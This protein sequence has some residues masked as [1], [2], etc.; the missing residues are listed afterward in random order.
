MP[1]IISSFIKFFL[2]D[3]ASSGI[4]DQYLAKCHVFASGKIFVFID[5]LFKLIYKGKSEEQ[6]KTI[7]GEII[8]DNKDEL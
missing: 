6:G 2:W 8:E 5:F 4:C 1:I 7:D 3:E